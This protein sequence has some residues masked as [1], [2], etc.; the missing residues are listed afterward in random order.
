MKLLRLHMQG[1]KSFRDKTTIYFDKGITGIVGPNGC[2]KSN[3]VDALFWV[4]GE[5][6]AKHLRGK[7]MQDLIFSGSDKYSPASFA[8]VTLVLGN[9]GGKHIH[10]GTQIAKPT[11]IQ[12]T[13]KLYR[14]G[15]TEYR[16]N[17]MPA[18]LKDIQEV[19]MDTGAGAKSYSII[20]QGEINRLVQAK[21]VERRTMIEEVAGITKFKKRKQES[22][23]KIE[24]TQSNLN[25]LNDL[26]SEI[27]KNLKSLEKQAEK[28]E[29]AK[30]LKEKVK[31]YDLL[32]ESHKEF[33]YLKDFTEGNDFVAKNSTLLNELTLDKE[34]LELTLKEERTQKKE[35]SETV[36]N[37]QNQY[38]EIS[39]KLAGL[40][41]KLNYYKKSYD[42]KK[43]YL[44]QKNEEVQSL[45]EELIELEKKE[46]SAIEQKK[47]I[48]EEYCDSSELKKQEEKLLILK[49]KASEEESRYQSVKDDLGSKQELFKTTKQ[50]QERVVTRLQEVSASLEDISKE[51]SALEERSSLFSGELVREKEALEKSKIL[52]DK[53]SEE[54]KLTK[55]SIDELQENERNLTQKIRSLSSEVNKIESKIQSLCEINKNLENST[56]SAI[57][58][59][60]NNDSVES[61][62]LAKL[63]ECDKEYEYAIES[64]T[65]S[66]YHSL[67]STKSGE[68]TLRNWFTNRDD[69]SIDFIHN[70]NVQNILT[71]E[72]LERLKVKGCSV[73]TKVNNVIR[74]KDERYEKILRDFFEG[75]LIVEN[76]NLDLALKMTADLNFKALISKDGRIAVKKL[77]DSIQI[78]I[79]KEEDYKAGIVQRNNE[80]QSLSQELNS[81]TIVLK[82]NEEVL[83]NTVTEL[84]T[85]NLSYSDLRNHLN[86]AQSDYISKKSAFDSR[87]SHFETDHVRIDILKNRKNELSNLKLELL[88]QEEKNQ[89]LI[90]TLTLDISELET[91]FQTAQENYQEAKL[92]LDKENQSFIELEVQTRTYNSRLQSIEKQIQDNTIAIDKAT[93]RFSTY[94]EQVNQFTQELEQLEAQIEQ[95]QD[96][97][98]VLVIEVTEK[99]ST[100]NESKKSLNALLDKMQGRE[101]SVRDITAK[102]NKVEKQLIEIEVKNKQIIEDEEL[103]VRN[104]FEKYQVDLRETISE[105]LQL[106]SSALSSLKDISSL[107]IMESEQGVITV[108]KVIYPFD[109]RYGQALRECKD[110]FRNYKAE[111][112]RLGEINWQAIEDYNHQKVRYDFLSVQ[113]AELKKSL[114]D[115]Q[116]AINH[117]D[118]KSKSRFNDAFNEVNERFEKVFPVIFGGG[119]ARLQIIGHLDDPECGIDIVAQPPGKKM[120][121]INLMSGGEKALTA[122]S[123][124]FSIFLVKPSP[125]CLLDE[126][127]APLDD[128]NVG[129]FNELLREMSSDSQFILITHNKKT[130]ELNDMLYGVTMQEPGISK[131]MSVQLH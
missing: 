128:A 94:V 122:V 53:L 10:I 30:T 14:N 24:Q 23:R 41:E 5:Q 11:E 115:L 9:E 34:K 76:L 118:H 96:E 36:E 126:V 38:N 27:Y 50:E 48:E 108:D 4:M 116:T 49:S 97:N 125:F 25:R 119:S 19:F 120:Q 56:E 114:T 3:I 52:F 16:I 127:D 57:E 106:Q 121:N 33:D 103:L 104:T 54:E 6:S 20:A 111:L 17:N 63:I 107:F 46:Q 74:I 39:K 62:F 81:K 69:V 130:M 26:Q 66:Y 67:I 86:K 90:K 85:K 82:E 47:T 99:E 87:A 129:R 80:I 28:A 78:S 93:L 64:L 70:V 83:A 29:R 18:R 102:I 35:L 22:L 31:K 40:E 101:G 77:N 75:L 61:E 2:G 131:A 117:I 79:R 65:Q 60:K 12:L 55:L 91:I 84:N 32:V 45:K 68:D 88:E 98:S 7:N 105:H 124:I 37:Y 44:K 100:L 113:E 123:L 110:K 58:Y 89:K 72:S 59:L 21:P 1:F 109:R 92:L 73:I 13:R 42:E 71:E 51:M 43:N 95:Q 8:E 15:E 112:N